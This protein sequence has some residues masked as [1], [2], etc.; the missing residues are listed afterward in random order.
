MSY[1]KARDWE[2]NVRRQATAKRIA[3]AGIKWFPLRY[4]KAPTAPA[5]AYDIAVGTAHAVAIARREKLGV[6]H[7]RSY[8]PAL[9]ALAVKRLTGAKFLFDMRGFWA[10]ERVDGGL[11][12]AGGRLYRMTKSLERHFLSAPTISSP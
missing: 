3:D 8:V 10:D 2:D 7:A 12:P 5:T 4:H 1:E 9:I 6:V 11:W